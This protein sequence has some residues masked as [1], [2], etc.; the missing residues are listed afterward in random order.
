VHDEAV[1][2]FLERLFESTR[3]LPGVSWRRPE[4][5]FHKP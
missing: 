2:A 1:W 3:D 4:D 5:L